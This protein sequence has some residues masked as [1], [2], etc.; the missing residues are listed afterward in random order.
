MVFLKKSLTIF[1]LIFFINGCNKQESIE[2]P[3]TSIES[4][5]RALGEAFRFGARLHIL[6]QETVA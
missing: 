6:L 1:M 5:M 2:V 4:E 3:I